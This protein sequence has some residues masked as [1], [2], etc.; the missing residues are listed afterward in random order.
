MSCSDDFLDRFPEDAASDATFFTKASDFEN[1]ANGLYGVAIRRRGQS[2]HFE[3][4][5]SNTDNVVTASIYTGIYERNNP[6][7]A[8]QTDGTWNNNYSYIRS[9]NYMLN[10]Q[11]K[12]LARDATGDHFIGEGYFM[13]AMFYFNLLQRFGGVPYIDEVLG[14]E[15]EDLYKPRESREFIA[16]K[17]IE[18]LDEAISLLQWQGTAPAVQGRINK[19]AALHLKTRVGLYEGSWERYHGIKGTPFAVSGSDGSVFLNAAVDAGNALMAKQGNT[20]YIGPAGDEYSRMFNND[21]GGSLPGVFL[22]RD[23][24]VALGQGGN[25]PR[26]AI[27]PPFSL[28]KSAVDNYLMSDGLPQ[29]ISTVTAGVD[30]ANQ[31]SVINTRD[32]RLRQT[33]YA[34]DRGQ[35]QDFFANLN[36]SAE[37]VRG[38]YWPA[39]YN[40]LVSPGYFVLKGAP[41][42]TVTID[43]NDIDDVI[44]RYGESLLNYAE[45]KAIL[46]TITQTDIDNTVNVLR[47]RVGAANMN[48]ATVNGWNITYL[49]K[50]GYDP[51]ADNIV[52]EIRRERR[53]E[54][55]LEGFRSDDLKRWAVYEDV[56]NG[57]IPVSAYYQ[58]LVDYHNI[59]QNLIDSQWAPG[60]WS[61]VK[62]FEGSNSGQ[63]NG[64]LTPLWQ[65]PDFNSPTSDG[66]YI[67]PGRDYLNSIPQVEIEHYLDKA[68][69]ELTQNPGWI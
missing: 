21:D 53:M 9:V 6:S 54:L 41:L 60:T 29:E 30:I 31:N 11:D 15:S 45:A 33:L 36:I 10:N 47:G 44:Y 42:T 8:S 16:T 38:I 51:S 62:Y 48:L 27:T 4:L 23:Y 39:G 19:E 61:E 59:D 40:R 49:E 66:Y 14:T 57:Y 17:I 50:D 43:L 58:E 68:N 67:E 25:R 26:G 52:N 69:V 3:T 5:D 1:F 56:I 13:R 2:N 18:D 37:G 20:I 24:N 28:T 65:E 32:P 22:A 55:M 46:G 12:L 34:P 64:Y 7:I 35:R 63:V